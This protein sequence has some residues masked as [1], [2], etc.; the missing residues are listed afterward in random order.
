LC[1]EAALVSLRRAYPTVYESSA[2]LEIDATKLQP[3]WGDFEASLQKIVPASR[4]SVAAIGRPLSPAAVPLLGKVLQSVLNRVMLEFYPA[5]KAIKRSIAELTRDTTSITTISDSRD[6]VAVSDE[7]PNVTTHAEAYERLAE[8]DEEAWVAT[9]ADARTEKIEGSIDVDERQSS[10]VLLSRSTTFR[11]RLL[12]SGPSGAGQGEIARAVLQAMDGFSCFSLEMGA[13]LA[14]SQANS[15]EQALL[16]RIQEAMRVAPSVVFLPDI[17]EWWRAATPPMKAA[18]TSALNSMPADAAVLWVSTL[19]SNE[20][21]NGSY[22][23]E[24]SDDG[25]SMHAVVSLLSGAEQIHAQNSGEETLGKYSSRTLGP[26]TVP[27]SAPSAEIRRAYF[28]PFFTEIIKLPAK[29]HAARLTML[30]TRSQSLELA[31][32]KNEDD[33]GHGDAEVPADGG[34]PL[35]R[36]TR[37]AVSLQAS[38]PTP[39]RS[40]GTSKRTLT[41]REKE[42]NAVHFSGDLTDY[43]VIDMPY[44]Y[45]ESDRDAAD[46]RDAYHLRELR[47]FCRLCIA[48]LAK[49]KRYQPFTRPIDPEGVPDYYDIV[50]CPCDLETMRSKVGDGLYPNIAYL[51]RDLQQICFNAK[52]YNPCTI[53]DVRGRQIVANARAMID[54]VEA[55][56]YRFKRNLGYDLFKRCEEVCQRR[57]IPPPLPKPTSEDT[58]PPTA[59]QYYADVL[60]IHDEVHE[61]FGDDHPT[62]VKKREEEEAKI[63][64]ERVKAERAAAKEEKLRRK[65][66]EALLAPRSGGDTTNSPLDIDE[67]GM[68]FSRINTAPNTSDKS[69]ALFDEI[70]DDPEAFFKRKR[71]AEAKERREKEAR[72]AAERAQEQ[73]EGKSMITE[74]GEDENQEDENEMAMVIDAPAVDPPSPSLIE[75]KKK[76]EVSNPIVPVVLPPLTKESAMQLPSIIRLNIAVCAANDPQALLALNRLLQ[77]AVERSA[78]LSVMQLAGKLAMLTR[79]ARRFE[80]HWEWDLLLQELRNAVV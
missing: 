4:R 58:L 17:K 48:E 13:L 25:D 72:E 73:K 77:L 27:I 29:V 67:H 75:S 56:A 80:S 62:E 79:A 6:A 76:G 33:S 41:K 52:E 47:N 45:T 2:R 59:E 66:E 78:T 15:P 54:T 38:K 21:E 40:S 28:T 44:G 61:E 20:S 50:K 26:A 24:E 51:L 10:H 30:L 22:E 35:R 65:S 7:V 1:S 19:D 36:S 55:Y 12:L 34:T 8:G 71:R 18:L 49:D 37:S 46:Q 39:T 3:S 32:E 5:E 53:K 42:Q 68:K 11:P 60:E 23:V 14:D 70:D 9:M 74:S 63:E 57:G 43:P 69:V 64:A 16:M 31:K